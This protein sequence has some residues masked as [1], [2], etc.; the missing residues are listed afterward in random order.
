[1][2]IAPRKVKNRTPIAPGFARQNRTAKPMG[3]SASAPKASAPSAPTPGPVAKRMADFR[4]SALQRQNMQKASM[5]R[6]AGTSAA[7]N[8]T[9]VQSRVAEA[10]I[11][12][13]F[14][15]FNARPQPKFGK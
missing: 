6:Y 13:S 11:A 7:R 2:P 5:S 9:Q 10:K 3:S 12:R 15:K 1:M 14:R 4:Q 8:M